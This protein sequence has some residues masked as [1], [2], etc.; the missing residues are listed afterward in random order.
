[1]FE[2]K[3]NIIKSSYNDIISLVTEIAHKICGEAFKL[4]DNVLKE[5]TLQAIKS[6]KDK[7]TITIIVNPELAEKIYSVSDELK[8]KIFSLF[9]D[10]ISSLTI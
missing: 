5:I 10:K 2:V 1:M 3:N 4:E 9:K 7:E 8:E 6:L